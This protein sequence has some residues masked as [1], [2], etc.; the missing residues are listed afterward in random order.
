LRIVIAHG[1]VIDPSQGID[2][3]R[4]VLI[5]DG[6]V[7]AAESPGQFERIAGIETV[8]DA[9]G[10]WVLPGLVDMHVHLREPGFEYKE[11]IESGTRAAL[12]G[13]ITS[14]ACMANTS[15]VNDS[16]AVT[17]YIL[18]KASQAGNA[19][20]FPIGA[21]SVGLQ[22]TQL[23]EIGEMVEAGIVAVSDDGK[24]IVSGSLMRRA[25]EYCR[26]FSLPVITH[27]EDPFL[28]NGGVINEG[29]TSLRLGLKGIP[30]AA[31]DVMVARDIELARL[32]GGKLHVAHA[33]TRGVVTL[34]RE[35]KKNGVMVTA[36]VTPHHLFLTEEAVEG[37][38]PNAKMNPPLRTEQDREA[39][40][41]GL[42][43][44]TID[45]I[46]TDH[47][48]QHEDEKKLEFENALNGVVGLETAVPI[49]LELIR[50]GVLNP[51]QWV[52]RFSLA[53]ARIL[54]IPAGSLARGTLADITLIDPT[55][56]WE[57]DPKEFQSKGRNSPFIGWQVQGQVRGVLVGGKLVWEQSRAA[58]PLVN[59][60]RSPVKKEPIEDDRHASQGYSLLSQTGGS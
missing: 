12:A 36:E 15:P 46:A 18:E 14:V 29:R 34:I 6:C 24:P 45:A 22:G 43:D 26:M 20:V 27:A 7:S 55:R 51:T 60:E 23:A 21:V 17:R 32:T 25:L 56:K 37:Y 59:L 9:T 49:T 44:G 31:E 10:L 50:R 8:I 39:L 42:Q 33:S 47:A 5:E 30:N 16:A 19:R 13:G 4:D 58:S 48:P 11:T 38:N 1:R 57:I 54:G 40:W 35:A 53:P 2:E 41:E 52:E 3:V 28:Q